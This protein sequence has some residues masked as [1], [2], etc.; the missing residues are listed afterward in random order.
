MAIA[1]IGQLQQ[2][3][4]PFTSTDNIN[5]TNYLVKIGISVDEKEYMPYTTTNTPNLLVMINGREIQIGST[6]IYQPG[7]FLQGVNI[8]FPNGA[9]TSTKVDILTIA[10]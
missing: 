4:G 3:T 2:Y 8:S 9:P 5:I 10:S 7:N 6:Y 1:R